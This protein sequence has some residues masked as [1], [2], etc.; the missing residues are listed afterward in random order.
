LMMKSVVVCAA[1]FVGVSGLKW[2]RGESE[3]EIQT[4]VRN[5]QA[6]M[7]E[8]D[9][10][11]VLVTTEANVRYLSGWH[12]PFWQSPTRPWFIVVPAIGKPVAVVPTIGETLF[13]KP[14]IGKVV[15]WA[16][17]RRNDDGISELT[18]VFLKDV[19]HKSGRIGAELGHQMTV[20]MPILDFE[21][22]RDNLAS[23]GRMIVDAGG[24]IE[25]TRI[26]KTEA[27]I[28]KMAASC[29][30][31][32]EMYEELPKLIHEGMTE[33]EA[34]SVV[35]QV[36]LQKGAD[37]IPYVACR[38]GAISY[39][40]I[41]GHP[42]ERKLSP[43][44]IFYVDTGSQLDGYFCDFNR[45][46]PVGP[47]A[48]EAAEAYRKLHGAIEEAIGI[49]RPGVTFEELYAVMAGFMDISLEGGVGRMGHSVGL[50]LTEGPSIIPGERTALQA[51]MVIALEP[52]IALPSG[53]GRFLALEENV[54]I[55]KRGC[56]LISKRA[57]QQMRIIEVGTPPAP[58]PE[59]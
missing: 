32:S 50:Q 38:S 42:T 19:P 1:L 13:E 22:L 43:G 21:R 11:A 20:R 30:A 58:T 44:D 15:T 56:R 29:D 54:A 57:P 39:T 52:S 26:V 46:F 5:L 12:S 7:E 37:E 55:T 9:I 17:P 47:P 41:I 34:C 23:E 49:A 18:D 48:A 10:D 51:G 6:R 31:V 25:E 53:Q 14:H 36:L 3:D 59:L 24:V 4:H 28:A 2:R 40:D 33:V 45:N 16:A 8:Q 27:E 35:K